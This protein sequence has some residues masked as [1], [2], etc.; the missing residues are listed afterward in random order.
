MLKNPTPSS[1]RQDLPLHKSI[2]EKDPAQVN[3]LLSQSINLENKDSRGVTPFL[4]AA[5]MGVIK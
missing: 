4:L 1:Q 2:A 5:Q 3:A